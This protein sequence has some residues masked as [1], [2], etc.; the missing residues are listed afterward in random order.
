MKF[1][2]I[3]LLRMVD[4]FWHE[5]QGWQFRWLGPLYWKI[6]SKSVQ[7]GR[8]F[9][10]PCAMVLGLFLIKSSQSDLAGTLFFIRY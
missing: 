9:H 5:G 1:L 3:S 7:I 10:P 4:F 8:G 6:S 2:I